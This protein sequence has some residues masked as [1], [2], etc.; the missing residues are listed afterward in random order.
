MTAAVIAR[1]FRRYPEALALQLTLELVAVVVR[2][3]RERHSAGAARARKLAASAT[4]A[5]VDAEDIP[6]GAIVLTPTGKEAEVI[7]YRGKRRD[8]MGQR[9]WC[10]YLQ[11]ENKRFDKVLLAPKLVT[12]IKEKV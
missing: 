6:L 5:D 4:R 11:P 1:N 7:G 10:R 2:R 3:V 8:P 9:L 12:V